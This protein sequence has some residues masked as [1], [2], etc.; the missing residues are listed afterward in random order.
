[1]LWSLG[2]NANSICIIV[3]VASHDCMLRT[4]VNMYKRERSPIHVEAIYTL[5]FI[6]SNV[7]RNS[8]VYLH[9]GNNG[10]KCIVNWRTRIYAQKYI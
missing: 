7:L 6:V 5:T 9:V 3:V 8:V 2:C 4:H 1:M 10:P